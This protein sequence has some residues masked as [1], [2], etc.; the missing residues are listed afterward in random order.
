MN[1]TGHKG[2]IPGRQSVRKVRNKTGPTCASQLDDFTTWSQAWDPL[3]PV[4][5]LTFSDPGLMGTRPLH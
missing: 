2:H 1:Y 3:A 4:S 5:T